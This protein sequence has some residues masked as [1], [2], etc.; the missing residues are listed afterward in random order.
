MTGGSGGGRDLKSRYVTATR[1]VRVAAARA[2]LLDRLDAS[3]ARPVRHLRTML[4]VHDVE[5]LARLDLPWWTYRATEQVDAFLAGRRGARVFEFGSG[6][7]TVWLARRAAEVHSVEHDL[8]FAGV[9]RGLV[10]DHGG[11]TVHAVPARVV[12]PGEQPRVRSERR[13]YAGHDFSEYVATV[14][15][16]GGVFD[17]VV[18]DGRARFESLRQALPHLAADGLV[19]FDNVNRRRYR[20]ALHLPGLA[21][22]VLRGAT[23]CLPYPT[24]TALLRRSGT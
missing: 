7:S 1:A 4:A 21:V 13:G 2:G 17:L 22:R 3:R 9:V 5:D 12:G 16:V 19:V 6:A 11:V 23:P 14:E 24:A 18:V 10:G 15:R 20:P 8:A